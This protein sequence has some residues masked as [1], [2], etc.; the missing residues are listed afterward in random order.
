MREFLKQYIQLA[1]DGTTPA[2]LIIF[3]LENTKSHD[4]EKIQ[5]PKCTESWFR[6]IAILVKEKIIKLS[7]IWENMKPEFE[8]ITKN[9]LESLDNT[10]KQAGKTKISLNEDASDKNSKDKDNLSNILYTNYLFKPKKLPF[11]WITDLYYSK[12]RIYRP[13]KRVPLEVD[14]AERSI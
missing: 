6:M 14:I 13:T 10:V 2:N 1:D 11:C 7:D 4:V 5:L 8:N 12:T 9:Y 3:R